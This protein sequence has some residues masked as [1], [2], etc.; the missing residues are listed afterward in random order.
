MASRLIA[1]LI[2]MGA[3]ML[4]RAFAE[5]YRQSLANA[6]RGGG[7]SAAARGGR[8]RITTEEAS[9]ILGVKN[10]AGLKDIYQKYDKLFPAND[11][12]KGG[13]LYIQA[14]IHNAKVELE[15]AAE[16]R[17]ETPRQEPATEKKS[18]TKN[19]PK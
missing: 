15:R 2:L 3:G 19:V 5:A 10:N 9:E 16:E 1:Q 11:P 6:A 17:G 4:G 13:S 14:K 7:A 18:E 8:R 12:T